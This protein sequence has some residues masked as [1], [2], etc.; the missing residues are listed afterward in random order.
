[1]PTRHIAVAH[2]NIDVAVRI[3]VDECCYHRQ[4][5]ACRKRA[6]AHAREGGHAIAIV[7]Q[8]LIRTPVI[9][10]GHVQVA[11]SIRV[12]KRHADEAG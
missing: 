3:N 10:E 11:I 7:A 2:Q 9:H 5:G 12:G 4:T 8:K 1:M 6:C